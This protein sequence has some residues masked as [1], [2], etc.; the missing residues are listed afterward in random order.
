MTWTNVPLPCPRPA[1]RPGAGA[2]PECLEGSLRHGCRCAVMQAVYS[3]PGGLLGCRPRKR[4]A[5]CRSAS[6]PSIR[7]SIALRGAPRLKN[8]NR[9][10]C[11]CCCAWRTLPAPSSAWIVCSQRCGPTWSWDRRPFIRRYRSSARFS[12][13]QIRVPLISRRFHA[14][15]IGSLHQCSVLPHL[16][17]HL[18][19]R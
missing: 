14:K 13:M 16:P 11:D 5:R 18:K 3:L 9:E 19:R 6:G 2:R 7:R 8:S 4:A 12:A 17:T 10:R 1:I 15:A